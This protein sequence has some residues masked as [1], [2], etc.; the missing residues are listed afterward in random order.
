MNYS[1]IPLAQTIVQLCEDKDIQHIVICP[2]SRNA[3]L[4]IGFTE[5]PYFKVY[6]IVDERVAAFFAMGISQQTGHPAAVV[7]TSGSAVLNFY[8]AIA[9]AY[10]S[11]IPLIIISADR[12]PHFIDIGD[13]QTIRQENVFQNHIL[14]SA[15]LKIEETFQKENEIQLNAAI[16]SSIELKGP[17]HINAPF[18]EPLYGKTTQLT[19]KPQNVPL[20]TKKNTKNEVNN[21]DVARW[22]ASKRKLILVGV[23]K[24]GTLNKEVLLTWAQDPSVLVITETTSN[25]HHDYFIC[26]IDQLIAP[27][28]DEE[29]KALQPDLLI[30][31]GGM[32]VSKK[33]KAFLR[34]YSAKHH[35]HIDEKKAYDTFF[36]LSKHIKQTPNDFFTKLYEHTKLKKSDFQK[37]WLLKKKYRKLKH[38]EYLNSV[39]FSDLKVF[40]ELFNAL[41]TQS[42]L[43][44]GNSSAIRYAQL[45]TL[46]PSISV[47]CNRGTSGI[48]GSN[49]T[50]IGFSVASN[51][52]VTLIT[53]DLSFFYDSN[54]LWNNYIPANFR[55]IL[56]NNQGGGIFRILPGEKSTP[57]FDTYF[58]TV[59]NLTAKKLCEMHQIGYASVNNEQ[60][61]KQQLSLFFEHSKRPQLL[62]IFT[63]REFNDKALLDYFK[64]IA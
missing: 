8:P 9:E 16:N 55:I 11:D 54:A 28:S 45:F 31:I 2:G 25:L 5:N 13:G 23:L 48:D 44:I 15:N 1:N 36:T 35:W 62:E 12:P 57:N 49:S 27:F 33:V 50:A 46:D 47:Y 20:S 26:S 3:P 61:L 21:D 17:V 14:Y 4:A 34:N 52:A 37:T 43:Q 29:F 39:E 56:I 42:V 64:F 7:C 24:P 58:E 60:E 18:E 51:E 41:P 10:Y 6:S 19:V 63:P 53:G 32:V 40:N 59:H 38:D 30:T 22:N